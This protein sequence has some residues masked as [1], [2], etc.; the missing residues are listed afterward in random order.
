M[1]RPIRVSILALPDT[2]ISTIAGMYDVFGLFD[3]LGSVDDAVPRTSPFVVDVLGAGEPLTRTA[4]GLRLETPRS[5]R[6]VRET[7][8]VI[9]PAMVTENAD[10]VPGRYP[11]IVAWLRKVHAAGAMLCSA[12]SGV[13]LLA[14]T[15]LL[16]GCQVTLHWTYAPTFSRNF[17]GINL[18]LE[19]VLIVTGPREEIVMSGGS[20]SWHDLVLYLVARTVGTAAA[21]AI[22]KFMLL[23]WHREGQGPYVGFVPPVDHGDGTVRRVQEWIRTQ[24]PIG[25]PIEEMV[26]Q[27]GLP[28][29]TFKRRFRRATGLTPIRYVQLLRIEEAKRQ[30]ERT[31]APVD[32]IS[33][34][35]GYEDPAFFRRLFKRVTKIPPGDYRRKFRVPKFEAHAGQASLE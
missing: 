30:L 35:V 22:A 28:P 29:R 9:I 16:D 15:G 1:N 19:D 3:V 12:C 5:I 20:A 26:A 23:Q 4:S 6:D 2:T 27:S 17:P 18:R 21:T 13:L 32:E 34:A 24:F 14:E 33:W 7:D 8:I 11:E 25:N 31:D 10:W